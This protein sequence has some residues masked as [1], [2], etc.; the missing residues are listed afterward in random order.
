MERQK[1]LEVR[2]KTKRMAE[3]FKM[4]KRNARVK[5]RFIRTPSSR[6]IRVNAYPKNPPVTRKNTNVKGSTK[7]R[8]SNRSRRPPCPGMRLP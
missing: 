3:I 1:Y 5:K 6:N 2:Q 7:I 8:L 4:E